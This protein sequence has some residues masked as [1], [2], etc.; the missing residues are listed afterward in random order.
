MDNLIFTLNTVFPIIIL[1]LLGYFLKKIN[2]FNDDFL[3]TAN[4]FCFY[5]ALPILL[6]KN[7]FNA[8]FA[9]I[10]WRFIFFSLIIILIIFIIGLIASMLYTK[11]HTKRGV[12][13]Q[14][15]F[16]SN[17]AYIGIP[18][19]TMLYAGSSFEI[20]TKAGAT[21]ALIAAF[22]VPVFNILAVISLTAFKTNSNQNVSI[23]N[24]IRKIITNPLIISVFIGFIGLLMRNITNTEI[25]DIN[26]NFLYKSVLIS[27]AMAS[28]LSLI[29]L[30][31]GFTFGDIKGFF[32]YVSF[33]VVARNIFVPLFALSLAVSFG[34]KSY[35]LGV[36]IALF[37]SPVAVSSAIMAAEMGGD[38]KLAGQIVVWTT[39]FS[40]ITIFVCIFIFK[41]LGYL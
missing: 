21:A 11:D 27:A 4:R 12:L 22:A 26:N 17:Y 38:G 33:S 15:F 39:I 9:D 2:F 1:V 24:I 13:W 8:D 29:I 34:F 18:L 6:F 7:V 31:G 32:K 41:S 5:V 19:V 40:S 3:K 37:A 36:L 30:G 28:P 10:N 14:G 25:A 35:E 23:K 16:R 20:Q